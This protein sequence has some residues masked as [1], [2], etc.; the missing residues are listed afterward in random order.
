MQSRSSHERPGAML[1]LTVI[2]VGTT[3][4]L[5]ALG[6]AMR[7]IEEL[8]M[9]LAEIQ[10]AEALAVAEGCAQEAL[11]RLARDNSYAGATLSVGDGTCTIVV[12]DVSG[13][14]EVVT[15]GTVNR[16]EH[17]ITISVDVSGSSLTILSWRQDV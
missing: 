8:D 16:W 1:L 12:S 9:G 13:N 3:A 6:T 4:L 14:K 7:G 5:I 11:L 15:T 10:S 2:I 17:T